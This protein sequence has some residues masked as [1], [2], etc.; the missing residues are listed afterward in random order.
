M[1]GHH[2]KS[3]INMT[4][5]VPADVLQLAPGVAPLPAPPAALFVPQV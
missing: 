2:E 3:A 1:T 5:C 4:S